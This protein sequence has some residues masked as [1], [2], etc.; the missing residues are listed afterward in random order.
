VIKAGNV[1]VLVSRGDVFFCYGRT[2]R[3]IRRIRTIRTM[4][5]AHN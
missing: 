5:K 1:E 4:I 2:I 3:R